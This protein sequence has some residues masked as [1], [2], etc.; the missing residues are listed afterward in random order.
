MARILITSG[1]TRQ[2]LD[3]VRY[4]SNA[5]GGRMGAALAQAALVRGHEVT[6]ISGPV[7]I[8]YPQECQVLSVVTTDDMM[9]ACRREFDR[10]DGVIGAAAPCDYQPRTVLTSKIVK[11]GQPLL[12]EL[13]E[14]DDIIATLG[15]EKRHQWVVG[16]A[17]ETDDRHF[18]AIT[19]LE[20]KCCDLIVLNDPSAMDSLDNTVDILGPQGELVA[21]ASGPKP[22][23][24]DKILQVIQERLIGPRTSQNGL[25]RSP[26]FA[27]REDS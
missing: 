20:K 2:Y 22:L 25:E 23:V 6:V 26:R 19:K 1:P 7:A 9:Q 3:P 8:E 11:D 10:C 5:S 24:A 13:V 15:R 17:L 4:L 21:T 18:R 12:L 27:F 14:T 16:F